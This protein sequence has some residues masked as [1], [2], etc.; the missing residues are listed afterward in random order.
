MRPFVEGLFIAAARVCGFVACFLP[1]ALLAAIVAALLSA[2][3]SV[4]PGASVAGLLAPL[5]VTLGLAVV[6]GLVGA[7]AGAGTALFAHELVTGV[8]AKA[9]R[10][11]PRFAAAVPAVVVG[12]LAAAIVLPVVAARSFVAVM[13]VAGTVV[14]LCVA[15]RSYSLTV[16]A[17]KALPAS[18]REAALALGADATRLTSQVIVPATRRRLFGIYIDAVSRG[19]GEATALSIVFASAVRMGYDLKAFSIPAQMLTHARIGQTFDSG[20]ALSALFVFALCACTR[21]WAGRLIGRFEW[22]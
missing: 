9:A 18:L 13:V 6:G 16:R 20:L 12:W 5:V 4:A 15:A 11:A 2:G 1:L 7:T 22:A 14:A 3:W 17:L 8:P 10:I 19:L 21:V